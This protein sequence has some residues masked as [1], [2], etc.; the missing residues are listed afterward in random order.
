MVR[1]RENARTAGDDGGPRAQDGIRAAAMGSDLLQLDGKHPAVVYL[2]ANLVGPP[3]TG[4]VW[5]GRQNLRCGLAAE[6]HPATV[7]QAPCAQAD[8]QVSVA[9]KIPGNI[10]RPVA[11]MTR[12]ALLTINRSLS[13]VD[14]G[15]QQG[16]FS[17]PKLNV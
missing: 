17:P 11:S 15:G 4:L 5:A 2:A 14:V 7:K 13:P 1:R 9:R 16:T 10:S 3:D 8:R 12:S 6:L